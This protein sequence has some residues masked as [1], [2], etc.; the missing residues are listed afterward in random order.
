MRL[1]ATSRE[2]TRTLTTRPAVVETPLGEHE[3][4]QLAQHLR[5]G[6]AYRAN[7]RAPSLPWCSE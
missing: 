7:V 6:V 1:A 4:V 5:P 2:A 3:G